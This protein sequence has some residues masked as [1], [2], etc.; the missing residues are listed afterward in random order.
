MFPVFQG[1]Y[2]RLALGFLRVDQEAVFTG[3]DLEQIPHLSQGCGCP[4]LE[5][6]W[7]SNKSFLISIND[8][9]ILPGT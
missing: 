4:T 8:N 5:E 6:L 1:S 7:A 3:R 9:T 2:I